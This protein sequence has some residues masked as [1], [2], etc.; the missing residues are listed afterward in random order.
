[1]NNQ[2]AADSPGRDQQANV[3]SLEEALRR[4]GSG[5]SSPAETDAGR[6]RSLRSGFL[7]PA[8]A[9]RI[10]SRRRRFAGQTIIETALVVPLFFLLVFAVVDF[11]RLFYVQMS[12]QDAV[13]QAGRFASTGNHLPDPNNPG[14]NLTRVQ[15]IIQQAIA[16]NPGL[17]FT[18]IK[19]SS[20]YGGA[21][22]AGGPGD[23]VTISLTTAL[24]LLT[25]VIA[26][27]FQD[28]TYTFVVSV[29]FKNEP[30]APS[31]TL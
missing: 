16:Q 26:P 2:S 3:L 29:S 18:N 6:E 25:P 24:K 8:N 5:S 15:S 13:R 23:T 10:Q 14:Q 22:N 19:I 17:T 7:A 31:N 4:A 21:G 12:L 1:M 9:R 27:F 30:F 28:G 20:V 11:G